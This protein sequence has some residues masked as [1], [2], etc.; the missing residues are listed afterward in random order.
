MQP[1]KKNATRKQV[2]L[3]IR[4]AK[5]A[6]TEA[7][8]AKRAAEARDRRQRNKATATAAKSQVPQKPKQKEQ[9]TQKKKTPKSILCMRQGVRMTRGVCE[10][11]ESIVEERAIAI[12][13]VQGLIQ[14]GSG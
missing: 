10:K 6:A 7:A 13:D 12:S 8:R 2:K 9:K 5:K 1:K 11:A 14:V 3:L 4:A